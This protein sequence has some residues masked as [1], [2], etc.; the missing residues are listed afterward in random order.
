MSALKPAYVPIIELRAQKSVT[1]FY[2]ADVNG[3]T[4]MECARAI[5]T[6]DPGKAQ[7]VIGS[8]VGGKV[9]EW[10]LSDERINF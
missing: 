9:L 7:Q 6:R 3:A 10:V 4:T 1:R 2:F 8:H 5:A